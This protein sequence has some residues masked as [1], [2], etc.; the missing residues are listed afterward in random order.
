VDKPVEYITNYFSATGQIIV[1]LSTCA[2]GDIYLNELEGA[3]EDLRASNMKWMDI[4]VCIN[5]STCSTH[6]H[7]KWS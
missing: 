7:T 1:M 4:L 5:I 2:V 6:F 3:V